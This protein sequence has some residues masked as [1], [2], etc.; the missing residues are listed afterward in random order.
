VT[1]HSLGG[2]LA[3]FAAL[4]VKKNHPT[5]SAVLYTFGQ[6]RNGN[7]AFSN[8]IYSLYPEGTYY[9]IIHT[10]D[11]APHLPMTEQGFNHAGDEVWYTS[12][13]DLNEYKVCKNFEK[14]ESWACSDSLYVYGGNDTHW[15]YL[16]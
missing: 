10:T 3:T 4:D 8:Y 14:D 16:G 2:A 9:R 6:P 5:R 12:D 13:N 7:E 11:L 15:I 1:G